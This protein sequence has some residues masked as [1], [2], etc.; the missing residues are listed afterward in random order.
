MDIETKKIVLSIDTSSHEKLIVG[1]ELLGI[2][3]LIE[4]DF[5]YRKSQGV[6]PLIE[7]V[8]QENN[9]EFSQI[10]EIKINVGPGSFTGLR[11]GVCIANVLGEILQVP[12]NSQPV[13]Q[14]VE[15]IYS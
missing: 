11:V 2:K 3:K 4:E 1:L 8:I 10:T 12:V 13:G 6:L 14:K 5:D 7:K 15:P 9:L